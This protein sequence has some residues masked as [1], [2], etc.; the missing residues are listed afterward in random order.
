MSVGVME[1]Y[2]LRDLRTSLTHW[3]D[4]W[5]PWQNKLEIPRD[6]DEYVRYKSKARTKE[7]I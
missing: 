5:V 2:K 6:Q 4:H 3:V 1:D 7:S